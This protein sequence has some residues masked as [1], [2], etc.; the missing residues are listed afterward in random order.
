MVK[1][2]VRN[3]DLNLLVALDALLRERSV[4]AA[5]RQLGLSTSAMSRTLSR[6]RAALGDPVLVPAGRA[7]VATAHAEAIADE[8]RSLTAA[9]R[10]VLSPPPAVDI[11]EVRRDFTIRAN[12]AFVLLYAARL[13]AMITDAAPGMRLRF[14]PRPN[15]EIQPLRD[16]A[17]DLDIGVV[18]DDGAELRGQRLFDDSFIGV[19]RCGHPL[20]DGGPITA[21]RYAACAH[22]V[23]SRRGAFT[24]PVDDALAAL[25][26]TRKVA[27]VVP[28]YPSVAAVAAASDLVGLVPRSYHP[29]D[30]AGQTRM[31]EL[32]VATPGFVIAQT[33][34]PR[35]DA[36]PVHR[37]LRG[38]IFETFRSEP[39]R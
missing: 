33:W 20:F 10:A 30:V 12:D 34:H 5:A 1:V 8:V 9:V 2:G 16:A 4:S 28:N 19:A 38:L 21:E 35:L 14:A 3:L 27:L 32:P 26:L 25:G 18:P 24:G 7:M 23:A 15:K 29:A 13:S 6:L 17:I 22:V 11:R 31:F 36:D 39:R 37:W